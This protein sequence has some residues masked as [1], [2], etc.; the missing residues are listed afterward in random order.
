MRAKRLVFPA[1]RL[2]AILLVACSIAVRAQTG[3][4]PASQSPPVAPVRPVIDDYHGTKVSDPYRYME[5]LQDPEVQA[6]FKAQDDYTRAVLARVPGSKRLLDRIK[7]LDQSAP[8]HVGDVQRYRG[9]KYYYQ[10][11]LATEEVSRLYVREGLG[12]KEK[13]LVDPGKFVVT[14]GTHYSLNYYVPSYDGRYVAYGVSPGGSEDAVIHILDTS[15]GRD[16]S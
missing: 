11:T 15:T 16:T 13:L 2:S 7:Q 9:E 1:F 12:G 8:Y 4:T 3:N 14:P 6:W 5:N 10:K